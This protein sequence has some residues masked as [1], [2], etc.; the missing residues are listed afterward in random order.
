MQ[1]PEIKIRYTATKHSSIYCGC[2]TF[3]VLCFMHYDVA[4]VHKCKQDLTLS[5]ECK[6]KTKLGDFCVL[7]CYC[8]NID[9]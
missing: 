6:V 3:P 8:V 2:V 9:S 1:I 5:D 4:F 7:T